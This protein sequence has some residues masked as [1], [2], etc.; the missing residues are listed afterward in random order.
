MAIKEPEVL[1]PFA[2]AVAQFDA[3]ADRLNLSQ[4]LRAILRKPKRELTV[5]FP[6]RMDDG[7]VEMFTGYRV[8]HN[9]NRGPA[10]GGIR[11][12]A[13]VTLDEVRALAMWMTWKCATVN[14]PFG[15]AKGG[16]I[17]DP[18]K[19]TRTELERMTRRYAT[20]IAGVIGPE[21][22]IPAPD[23]N[24]NPQVMAWIMDTYSMHHGYSI[25]AVVTGKPLSVGGSEGRMEATGRG[26]AFVTREACRVLNM[27]LEGARVVIQGFGNVGSVTAKLLHE[28]GATIIGLSDVYGA[29]SNE[30][31]ID[32]T[33]ALR[34]VQEHGQLS[35]LPDSV[36]VD[37]KDLLEL[38][39][40]I[41]IPA[42]LEGQ[43]THANADRIQAKLII[44]AANGPTTTDADAIFHAR[45]IPVV[46]DILANAGGVTVSYFEWVQDLQHFFWAEDEINKRLEHI[47]VRSFNAVNAKREEQSCD[48]RL[49][50]Y[51]LA[52]SRV[53]EATQVR[54]IYP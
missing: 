6:V 46:P 25:P 13:N 23:V 12:D 16:V 27:P 9:I 50:A 35:G 20:E 40:D 32:V 43:L 24:T 41:L 2:Q 4:E 7:R 48:F 21:S 34:H 52:V 39:C 51:L 1:N 5:N 36:S 30:K 49:G 44:E 17:V 28:M 8:Q 11:Y 3:A 33:R 45:G 19:L 18:R 31:G 29:I 14:I 42:A 47:M 10:K 22:D 54:G 37:G 26:V 15:G 38:P 53:A